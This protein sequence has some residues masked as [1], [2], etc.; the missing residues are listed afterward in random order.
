MRLSLN[1]QKQKVFQLCP[2]DPPTRGS[3][4]DPAG[5]FAPDPHYRLVLCAL[6]MPPL[7]KS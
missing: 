2:P 6:A 3:A 5:G 1:V 7:A 4:L